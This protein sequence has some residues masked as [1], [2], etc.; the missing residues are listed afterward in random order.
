MINFPTNEKQLS[1]IPAMQ[2]LAALG[3]Q[4]LTPEAAL[5]ERGDRLSEVL[6]ENILSEQLQKINRINQAGKEYV[7]S[8]ANIQAAI[9]KL[10]TVRQLGSQKT[11][12]AAYH[13]L[14][15]G[16]S[17]EQK[18]NGNRKSYSLRYI[19]WQNWQN[20]AFHA[21][22]EFS[23]ERSYPSET[24]RPDIV[25][26]VNG[27][28]LAV[29]ECKA[30]SV[31][32]KEAISQNIRNQ[33][34]D[35]IPKLFTYA[36]LL[37]AVNKNAAYYAT[38]GTPEKF[39]SIWKEE[40]D[41]NAV[42]QAVNKPLPPAAKDSLFVD[43]FAAYRADFD[44]QERIGERQITE[45]DKAIY[46][47]CRC[48]R[49]LD[50]VYRFTLF[51]HGLKKIA[52][53]Q[54]FFVVRKTLARI[55]Q[56]KESG[57]RHGG[58]IWHAQGS[59]KSLTMVM[60]ARA[61]ALPNS[62]IVNPRI[63]IVTDREDLD[64]QIGNTFTACGLDNVMRAESGRNLIKHLKNKA[65]II[66]TLI[67]KFD[68][69]W[70]AGKFIDDSAD[71]IVLVDESHRTN[72]GTFAAKMRKILPKAGFIGFTGTPLMREER[73]NFAKFGDLIQPYY[74]VR[75]AVEDKAVLPLLYEGRSVDMRQNKRAVDSWFKRHTADLTK[76][77]QKDL[78]K[79]YSRAGTLTQA[80]QVIYM[81]AFDISA[82][83]REHWRGTGFTAQLVAPSKAAALDY[84]NC[85]K[86][87][88]DVSSQVI[89]SAP[90]MREGHEEVHGESADKVVQFWRQMMETYGN[91][92]N[93]LSSIIGEYK[94][95]GCPEVLIVVDKLLTGFDAPRN[96]VLYLCRRLQEHTLLQAVARVNRLYEG[97]EFGYIVDYE[98]VLGELD[99][100]LAMY[101]E[102]QGFDEKQL[103]GT[104]TS[105][106]EEVGKLGQRHTDLLAIFKEVKNKNDNEAFEVWLANDEIR[107]DFYERLSEYMKTLKI[108]L[109]SDKFMREATEADIKRYKDDLKH[110]MKLRQAVQLRYAE[111]IDY[112]DYEKKIKGILDTHLHA[113]TVTQLNAAV[114]IFDQAAFGE[115]KEGR[116][117]YSEKSTAA[118]GDAIAHATKRVINEKMD[119]DPAF[120]QKFS[121]LIQ[122]AID[123]FRVRQI[124]ADEYL[125]TVSDI[126]NKVVERRHDDAP[127][128][129]RENTEAC[130]YYG[131]VLQAV[132]DSAG[133]AAE[134]PEALAADIALEVQAIIAKHQIVD[135]WQNSEAQR[136]TKKEID[137][138]VYDKTKAAFGAAIAGERINKTVEAVMRIAKNWARA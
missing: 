97:K 28:P 24:A 112:S 5:Q 34:V 55:A 7:F 82:H 128:R 73:N 62:G 37:M 99:K 29:I 53:Y 72:F 46:S 14:T 63:V 27:I 118:R 36:Q 105:I 126:R 78:K 110:F 136:K 95:N 39:W 77:Q 111:V 58:I 49:L 47:L 100:A 101:E 104:L 108:A 137:E 3:Y 38:T 41:E 1:Q 32:V 75:R 61:L 26:F 23:V 74:P 70:Q 116:G 107:G 21:V 44:A 122:D 123:A 42:Q 106:N 125:E 109:S 135:F 130:A 15:L 12:E 35:Y 132:A 11:N 91:E 68:K 115:L 86:E 119:E 85:L 84:H 56:L 138:C 80:K 60:L 16:E 127:E 117:I 4:I 64:K 67:H 66:T 10:K 33:G 52:R 94:N 6:L 98:G 59:G 48:E 71:I 81:R 51:E 76:E 9:E 129:I 30:P 114:N 121:K 79:K 43:G 13:L 93:Y 2:L 133:V 69:S 19:D 96:T 124:S 18:I 120:Y 65:D 8:E 90:D 25:L 22:C 45:Q 17:F 113:D 40:G 134:A 88:G 54:Q 87:I 89:I 131:V 57:E 102:L 20:N 83:Y 31:E 103:A 92:N 50:L